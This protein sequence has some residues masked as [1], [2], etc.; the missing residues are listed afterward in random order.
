MPRRL[1]IGLAGLVVHVLNRGARRQELFGNEQDYRAFVELVT[2]ARR[3]V[4]L[5]LLGFCVMPNH[6]HLVAWPRDD[7]ELPRFMQWL[8]VTH[9]NRWNRVRGLTGTG[10]VYQG[11]YKTFPA[12]DGD[13]ALRVLRYVERNALRARLVE[14]AEDWRWG[15]AWVRGS[16]DADGLVSEWPDSLPAGWLDHVNRPQSD[17]ELEALRRS[18]VR[19]TPFGSEKWVRT[20]TERARL[21]CTIRPP[22]RPPRGHASQTLEG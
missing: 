14:R 15:S 2:E 3:R 20:I 4:P 7:R 11:R 16:G 8:T 1:R 10:A 12:E 21:Q 13:A 22:G 18:V 17:G 6:W 9:A 19:G 5:R